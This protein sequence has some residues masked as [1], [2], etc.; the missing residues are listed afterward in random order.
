V[1]GPL[2]STF[3]TRVLKKQ[4]EV[5]FGDY[6]PIAHY[7]VIC[8]LVANIIALRL[9]PTLSEVIFEE[10]FDFLQR[11][12]IHDAVSITHEELHS[13]KLFN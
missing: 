4:D 11:R 5:S 12:Q 10:R 8:K 7:N 3:L 9:K 2:N 6:S 13:I 1:L